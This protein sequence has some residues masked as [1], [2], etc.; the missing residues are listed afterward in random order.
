MS[1]TL[2]SIKYYV[3]SELWKLFQ[4]VFTFWLNL[5]SWQSCYQI[6]VVNL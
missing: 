5:E 2:V 3:Q 1:E 4:L 6:D